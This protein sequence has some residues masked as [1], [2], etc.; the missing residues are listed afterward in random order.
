MVLRYIYEHPLCN[1]KKLKEDFKDEMSLN[2]LK[3][4]IRGKYNRKDN[5]YKEPYLIKKNYIR[6]H[7]EVEHGG[8]IYPDE[9]TITNEGLKSSKELTRDKIQK[10]YEKYSTIVEKFRTRKHYKFT[11]IYNSLISKNTHIKISQKPTSKEFFLSDNKNKLFS[12]LILSIIYDCFLNNPDIWYTMEKPEDQ[13]FEINIKVNMLNVPYFFHR[14]F[15][16]IRNFSLQHKIVIPNIKSQISS[17][18][19]H[20]NLQKIE[21]N[22]IEKLYAIAKYESEK[23]DKANL[24]SNEDNL[25]NQE[26]SK[27]SFLENWFDVNDDDIADEKDF[28]ELEYILDQIIKFQE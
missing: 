11:E 24:E 13:D 16:T 1:Y 28:E 8:K 17:N 5:S 12:E 27:I 4:Y 6:N 22:N 2:A 3:Y 25:E 26:W 14:C 20:K 18:F 19:I 10:L 9:F 23:R 7:K 21:I 15:K